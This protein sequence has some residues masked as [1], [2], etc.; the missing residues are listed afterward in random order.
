MSEAKINFISDTFEL[1][2]FQLRVGRNP[3]FFLKKEDKITH[4]IINGFLLDLSQ[5]LTSQKFGNALIYR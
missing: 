3:T 4:A 2:D 5:P 1:P